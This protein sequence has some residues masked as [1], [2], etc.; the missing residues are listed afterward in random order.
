VEVDETEI[1]LPAYNA[2]A[3]VEGSTRQRIGKSCSDLDEVGLAAGLGEHP[4]QMGLDGRFGDTRPA[5]F[6]AKSLRNS[7][8]RD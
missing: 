3:Q 1:Y 7:R 6:P 8:L 5:T 4:I 2:L